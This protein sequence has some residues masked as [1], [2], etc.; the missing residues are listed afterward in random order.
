M[1]PQLSLIGRLNQIHET[2]SRKMNDNKSRAAGY[3]E[4]SSSCMFLLVKHHRL[5]GRP[6]RRRQSALPV[7]CMTENPVDSLVKR[8]SARLSILG[9][10]QTTSSVVQSG[11]LNTGRHTPG[12]FSVTP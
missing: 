4:A 1:N 9:T 2:K 11:E 7:L 5:P 6:D 8:H 12:A 3:A 10:V